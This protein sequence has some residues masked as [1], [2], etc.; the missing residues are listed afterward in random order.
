MPRVWCAFQGRS[1]AAAGAGPLAPVPWAGGNISFT[2]GDDPAATADAR[3][4][5]FAAL[6]PRGL[7]TW[8][9][10]RQVH[11]D[12]IADEPPALAPSALPAYRMEDAPEADGMFTSTPGK[13]LLIKTADCQPLLL[14]HRSGRHVAA[15]HVGWRGNRCDFPASGLSRFCARHGLDPADVFAVRGPSLG[16]SRAEFVNFAAEWGEA[17]RPWFDEQSRCMDLWSLTASQL[18]SAGVPRHQIFGLDSCTSLNAD[19]YFSHRHDPASGRQASLVW[20]GA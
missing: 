10:V 4:A 2:S 14:A 5:L 17:F 20:I 8:A 6:A 1:A 13:G 12:A 16:P 18:E 15:L 3:R 9:E 19:R 11:G 7:R